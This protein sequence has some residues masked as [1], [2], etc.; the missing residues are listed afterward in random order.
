LLQPQYDEK[1]EKILRFVIKEKA[2]T[3]EDLDRVWASQAGKHEAT[4]KNVHDLLAKLAWDFSPEQ[5]DHLFECFQVFYRIDD[6]KNSN[7]E[8]LNKFNF[9]QVGQC[10]EETTRKAFRADSPLS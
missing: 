10:R 1:L 8:Y 2:L 3:L 4:V 7:N 6:L 5:L 9:R